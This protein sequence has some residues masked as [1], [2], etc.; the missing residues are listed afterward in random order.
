MTCFVT[1]CIVSLYVVS[2][3]QC[4]SKVR[5]IGGLITSAEG[6][7]CKGGPGAHASPE[8][9][10]SFRFIQSINVQQFFLV[11]AINK[12]IFFFLSNRNEHI[13]PKSSISSVAAPQI[14]RVCQNYWGGGRPPRS[15]PMLRHCT[16]LQDR[17]GLG[18]SF[19]KF[20]VLMK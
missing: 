17:P 2:S 1:V 10:N 9:L 19:W 11:E 5:F 4:R 3:L 7:S 8:I 14:K 16:I 15:L 6:T 12:Y 13:E 18:Y 20:D